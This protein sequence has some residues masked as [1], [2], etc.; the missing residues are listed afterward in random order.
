MK[1]PFVSIFYFLGSTI[2]FTGAIWYFFDDVI[3]TYLY[4]ACACCYFTASSLQLVLDIIA[5]RKPQL[6]L[7]YD[8]IT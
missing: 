8:I 2:F 7:E 3:P 5:C 6:K 1:I 4:M